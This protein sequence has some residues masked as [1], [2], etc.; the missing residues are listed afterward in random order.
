M[1]DIV[2]SPS[3]TFKFVCTLGAN[4]QLPSIVDVFDLFPNCYKSCQSSVA[5]DLKTRL[6]SATP[7]LAGETVCRPSTVMAAVA[8]SPLHLD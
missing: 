5:R 2:S 6:L 7:Y 4:A 3:F 1:L 8:Q